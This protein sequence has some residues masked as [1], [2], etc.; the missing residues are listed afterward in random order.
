MAAGFADAV[1]RPYV[2]WMRDYVFHIK[3]NPQEMGFP[4]VRAFLADSRIP[5]RASVRERDRY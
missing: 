3:R 4:E 2:S 1:A 5:G